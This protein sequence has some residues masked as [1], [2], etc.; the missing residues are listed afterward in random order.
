MEETVQD[1]YKTEFMETKASRI[2]IDD[3]TRGAETLGHW[4]F[5]LIP[6]AEQWGDL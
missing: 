5:E 2:K 3:D 1:W 6:Y 4:R